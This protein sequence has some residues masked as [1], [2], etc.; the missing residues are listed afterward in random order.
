ML[1]HRTFACKVC[2][3]CRVVLEIINVR[4]EALS[5]ES[6]RKGPYANTNCASNYIIH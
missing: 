2:L 5:Y 6:N 3:R 1:R 4:T